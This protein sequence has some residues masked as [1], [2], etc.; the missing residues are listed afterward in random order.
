MKNLAM[1]HIDKGLEVRVFKQG[2]KGDFSR[3]VIHNAEKLICAIE[4][5]EIP[6][7]L[8]SKALIAFTWTAKSDPNSDVTLRSD[9]I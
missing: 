5:I 9:L 2:Q 8:T 6:N 3:Y 1:I 7:D 4:N